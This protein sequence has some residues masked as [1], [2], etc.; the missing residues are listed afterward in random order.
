M[1][2]FVNNNVINTISSLLSYTNT[3]NMFNKHEAHHELVVT[4]T[5]RSIEL[6]SHF[7]F[8]FV[9][10]MRKIAWLLGLMQFSVMYH[11][12]EHLL[13]LTFVWI[14][15][16]SN[17]KNQVQQRMMKKIFFCLRYSRENNCIHF[18]SQKMTVSVNRRADH[19]QKT[20]RKCI[21]W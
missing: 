9:P 20:L 11:S 7:L 3:S 15:I 1:I 5:K 14:N 2:L 17:I 8:H 16:Q 19:F 18:K 21:M 12:I 13:Y 6:Q 4:E 10:E